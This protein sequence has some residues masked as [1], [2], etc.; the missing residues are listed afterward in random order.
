MVADDTIGDSVD[1]AAPDRSER[2]RWL[3]AANIEY[4]V[5]AS[6]WRYYRFNFG[7]SLEDA[8]ECA[9]LVIAQALAGLGIA[10]PPA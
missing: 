7:L 3:V 5:V 8:V 1:H 6:T 9:R 4:Q 10:L 2:E